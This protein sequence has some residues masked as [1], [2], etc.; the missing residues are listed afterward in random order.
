[1]K[2]MNCELIWIILS[3]LLCCGQLGSSGIELGSDG[4]FSGIRVSIDSGVPVNRTALGKLKTAFQLASEL[5]AVATKPVMNGRKSYAFG[6]VKFLLPDSWSSAG[7]PSRFGISGRQDELAHFRVHNAQDGSQ[8]PWTPQPLGCG[9]PGLFTLLPWPAVTALDEETLSRVI[10]REFSR[11]RWGAFA[12][13]NGHAGPHGYVSGNRLHP[14][15][16]SAALSGIFAHNETY[17]RCKI[18]RETLTLEPNCRFFL[19]PDQPTAEASLMYTVYIGAVRHFC[20][21]V[22]QSGLAHNPDAPNPHY[23]HCPAGASVRDVLAG[24]EDFR[25]GPEITDPD[26]KINF[27]EVTPIIDR[28][29]VVVMDVSRSMRGQPLDKMKQSMQ[30]LLSQQLADDVQCALISYSTSVHILAPLRQLNSSEARQ[31]HWGLVRSLTASGVTATGDAMAAALELLGCN[32][33]QPSRSNTGQ[34][35]L[36]TDGEENH[37]LR[38]SL[39]DIVRIAAQTSVTV[40]TVAFGRL[41]DT[42]LARLSATTGGTAHFSRFLG[43]VNDMVESLGQVA[44]RMADS[45]D[46]WVNLIS[47]QL[48]SSRNATPAALSFTVDSSVSGA[49]LQAFVIGAVR[50]AR[51]LLHLAPV[52][53][54]LDAAVEE[55]L[56]GDVQLGSGLLRLKGRIRPGRWK[57]Y[58]SVLPTASQSEA[59]TSLYHSVLISGQP[60]ASDWPPVRLTGFLSQLEARLDSSSRHSVHAYL[61]RGSADGF[62]RPAE[63]WAS[64]ESDDGTVANFQ[65]FD[66]GAGADVSPNDG[67]YSAYL[68]LHRMSGPPQDYSVRLRSLS[69]VDRVASA[70]KFTVTAVD[71]VDLARLPPTRVTD[72]GCTVNATSGRLRM[73]WTSVGDQL[74]SGAA[75]RYLIRA[76]ANRSLL[77]LDFASADDVGAAAQLP[78]VP[79][80]QPMTLEVAAADELP[81]YPSVT[82]Y[83]AVRANNSAGVLSQL[84]NVAAVQ[85][86]MPDNLAEIGVDVGGESSTSSTESSTTSSSESSTASSTESSTTSSTE[87]STTSSTES[88]TTSS[89]E[90]STASTTESST[91]SSSE[92]STTSSS[93]SSTTSSSESSTTS[94]SESSTASTTESSTTSSS[95]SST[96]STPK[97]HTTSS[98][99]SSTTSSSESSTAS[100]PKSHTTSSS[101]SSTTSSSESSTT[102]SSESSTTSST[103]SSTTTGLDSSKHSQ[104]WCHTW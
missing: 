35:L 42:R 64:V 85:L 22:G 30:N 84:S 76:S 101:E 81:S 75:S 11:L 16:C 58:V 37:Q 87:S 48:R 68:P 18:D 6:S 27:T 86:T 93:E 21:S 43:P 26:T 39:S 74:D 36:I 69:P 54:A 96:A 53:D 31:A 29:L 56:Q 95:E 7:L 103:E 104:S 3:A 23:R 66:H 13:F 34:V 94:S 5:L 98:S 51:V 72:F 102:S 8:E 47:S 17:G 61:H 78:S 52:G 71:S 2:L 55:D 88:S 49:G 10:L 100:T 90:S 70:G 77:E 20:A 19:Y 41:A 83:L 73:R 91:K 89:S 14:V 32:L 65:L 28:R 1:M 15:R 67:I 25:F 82:F 45:P 40:D 9:K 12:E 4:R 63:L 57:L 99:E 97:S 92:S 33:T 44:G 38:Y 46:A 79:S 24:H 59:A 80:G 62:V 50:P 60:A